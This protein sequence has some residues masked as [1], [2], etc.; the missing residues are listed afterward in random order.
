MFKESKLLNEKYYHVKHKSGLN[1]YIFPKDL[2]TSYAVFGTRYGS[3]DN[4][5]RFNN[6]TDYTVVPD[7]IAHFLE[8]KMFENEDGEDT[9]AK[10][11]RTG[12]SANAYTSFNMTV[13]L[14]SC[15]DRFYDSLEILLDYV[16]HPYFT[17]QT[18]EKEQGIISQ[19]IR[20]GEDNPGRSLLYGTLQAMYEKHNV[21]I[22]IA[23]T[24]ESISE[25]TADVLYKCYNTFYNFS[26][27]ALC[28]SGNV[29]LDEVVAV[30]DKI[31][32]EQPEIKI[33]S[34]YDKEDAKVFNNYFTKKMQVSKPLFSIGIKDVQIIRDTKERM[35]KSAGMAILNSILYG[36][37]SPFFNE[38]YEEGLIS[39]PLDCWN[40]HNKAFS[41]TMFSGESNDPDEIFKRFK[42]YIYV[43]Q[44]AGIHGAD[45]NRCKRVL[46][47]NTV[48]SFDSTD[49]IAN[50]FLNFIFEDG[51][52]FD[53]VDIVSQIDYNYI[54]DLLLEMYKEDYY[55]LATI[56]P[57][58][59]T[60]E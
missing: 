11:A 44:N 34:V 58:E 21:R 54:M 27:M 29:T 30:A 1:I 39:G 22:E 3:I 9:F 17:P 38:L 24:V 45:F 18:V 12:A 36:K 56:Y 55:S 47:A 23:G 25:I 53:F 16:T 8:H 42:K 37:S 7:G 6:E 4:K 46:Y 31:L 41:F 2:T 57:I 10:F 14:F 5:F 48:K 15:T 51:D 49:D 50:N 20:M 59:V 13:Y 32:P 19:E 33:E 43:M 28:V 60:A 52:I 26:N 40:E 35:K